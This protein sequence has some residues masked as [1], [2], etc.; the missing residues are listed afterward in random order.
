MDRSRLG[1]SAETNRISCGEY[2]YNRILD[3]ILSGALAPGDIFD[4]RSIAKLLG[5]SISPVGEAVTRLEQDG[6]LVNMP[7][8]GTRVRRSD[9][10]R[11]YES[12]LLREAIECQA[13]RLFHGPKLATAAKELEGLAAAAD[14]PSRPRNVIRG[15]DAAFHQKLVDLA[16]IERFTSLYA[17]CLRHIFF[18]ENNLISERDA[19]SDSHKKLLNDLLKSASVE[20]TSER[21]RA[22]LR[23]GKDGIFSR[24]EPIP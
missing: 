14:G 3:Q 23:R 12:L 11:L 16:G 8:K 24:F 5:V 4:R 9:V 2:V 10:C 7:R 22:H 17:N 20:Q 1:V 19:A 21:L 18:D 13:A 15:A 6:F